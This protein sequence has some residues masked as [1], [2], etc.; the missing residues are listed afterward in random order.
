MNRLL[1]YVAASSSLE[2]FSHNGEMISPREA[3]SR[4]VRAFKDRDHAI[5]YDWLESIDSEENMSRAEWSVRSRLVIDRIGSA[6]SLIYIPT[7]NQHSF[8]A[9]L[10]IGVALSRGIPVIV[11]RQ[12]H[13]A[14]DHFFL[15]HFKVRFV[16]TVERAIELALVLAR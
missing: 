5:V 14:F 13:P 11:V 4:A 7:P 8:G 15:S 6:D 3:A 9:P 12:Y 2:E 16:N 1:V 10:E